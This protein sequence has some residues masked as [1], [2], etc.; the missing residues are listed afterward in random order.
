MGYARHSTLALAG[1]AGAG[2]IVTERGQSSTCVC[3]KL[4]R[5]HLPQPQE[6]EPQAW[7]LG[8]SLHPQLGHEQVPP[9]VCVVAHC[10]VSDYIEQHTAVSLEDHT[11][12]K[13]RR[14]IVDG[15]LVRVFGLWV[16]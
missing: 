13:L 7:F 9:F 4:D 8:G 12:M 6:L 14:T 11:N 1:L 16:V 2:A 10:L 3:T 15:S 5:T